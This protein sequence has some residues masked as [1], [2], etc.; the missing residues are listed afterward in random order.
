M[1]EFHSVGPEDA[2]SKWRGCIP[3]IQQAVNCGGSERRINGFIVVSLFRIFPSRA[4]GPDGARVFEGRLL[5]RCREYGPGCLAADDGWGVFLT[6]KL[7]SRKGAV[8]KLGVVNSP[9]L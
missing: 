9:I 6:G 4:S 5:P 1:I 2:K 7:D 3:A 8:S